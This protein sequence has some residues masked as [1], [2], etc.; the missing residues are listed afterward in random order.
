M[1]LCVREEMRPAG[2]GLN[3]IVVSG[4]VRVRSVAPVSDRG[5]VDEV[6]IVLSEGLGTQFELGD[7]IRSHVVHEHVRGGNDLQE[8]LMSCRG[9]QIET[10]GALVAIDIH[11]SGAHSRRSAGNGGP[12][13]VPS[14]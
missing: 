5:A 12:E 1:A 13:G 10:D 9:F 7:G 8:R 4:P 11:E 14:W 2:F 6:W 3:H